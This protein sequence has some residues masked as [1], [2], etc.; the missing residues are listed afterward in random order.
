M[1]SWSTAL[2]GGIADGS[3]ASLVSTSLL[4]ALSRRET[5]HAW[6]ATNATSHWLWR[7]AS[8]AQDR[9]SARY[10]VSGYVI[11]H[12]ACIWW[13]VLAQRHVSRVPVVPRAALTAVTACAVDYLVCPKR[14]TP[15]YEERLSRTAVGLSYVACAVGFVLADRLRQRRRGRE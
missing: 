1:Q 8:F 10:T 11:H 9:A 6:A 4:V 5:G 12:L 14:L 2:R 15:G 13:A 3:C 7:G